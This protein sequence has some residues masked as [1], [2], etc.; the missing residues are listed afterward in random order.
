[1]SALLNMKRPVDY[2]GETTAEVREPAVGTL[3]ISGD[4]FL[5][6][7]PDSVAGVDIIGTPASA[8]E[9]SIVSGVPSQ[10]GEYNVNY[11]TGKVMFHSADY[12]VDVYFLYQGT[13]SVLLAEHVSQ[14]VDNVTTA[15]GFCITCKAAEEIT[16]GDCVY[17]SDSS[18]G[19]PV[20]SK[21]DVTVKYK[22]ICF[23]VALNDGDIGDDVKVQTSGVI[24]GY[25]DD[26]AIGAR[27]VVGTDGAM[28]WISDN[29][30]AK[31]ATFPATGN[32]ICQ[33]GLKISSDKVL[34]APSMTAIEY[35]A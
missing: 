23:G 31:S 34:L 20:V 32:Y 16:A 8:D 12:G 25:I 4:Y 5:A 9:F 21:G 27:V 29:T 26:A 19:N 28:A 13:G 14:L 10:S 24:E 3:T 33:M 30:L 35:T 22:S 15:G 18:F 2:R 17:V 1:M 11:S 7:L 6:E